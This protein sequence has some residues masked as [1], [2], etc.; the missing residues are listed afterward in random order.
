M[1][2]ADFITSIGFK[3]SRSDT[4]LFILRHG[5]EMAILLLYVDDMVLTASS[6]QRL[7]TLIGRL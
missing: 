6:D 7:R 5:T 4:S 3:P 1:R 2:F